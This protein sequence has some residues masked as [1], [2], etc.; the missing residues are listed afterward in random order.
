MKKGRNAMKKRLLVSVFLSFFVCSSL[1]LA[2]GKKAKE[3]E[4]L[5]WI[6]S[7]RGEPVLDLSPS[8]DTK[9][10][11]FESD[12]FFNFHVIASPKSNAIFFEFWVPSMVQWTNYIKRV[13]LAYIDFR[14][15][16]PDVIP[17]GIE[18]LGVKAIV[19]EGESNPYGVYG[20]DSAR[21]NIG[22]KLAMLRDNRIDWSITNK[23]T[24][25]EVTDDEAQN[26]LNSLI[27]NGFDVEVYTHGKLQGVKN[28][29]ILGASIHVTRIS[30][31]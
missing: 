10:Q 2:Q 25:E 8:D 22:W 4:H 17:E 15:I 18:V 31:N 21:S 27:D 28:L 12:V 6:E 5:A 16:N 3:L 19:Q 9:M 14:I 1:M 13:A 20:T 26:I 23:M 11:L 24:K 29:Y 7:S 30:K